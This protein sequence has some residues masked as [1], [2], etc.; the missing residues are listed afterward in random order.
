MHLIET[1]HKELRKSSKVTQ[2]IGFSLHLKDSRTILILLSI[3]IFAFFMSNYSL[4]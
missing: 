2:T 3:S 4:C 1:M